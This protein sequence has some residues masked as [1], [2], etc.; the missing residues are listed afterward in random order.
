MIDNMEK[1]SSSE[2]FRTLLRKLVNVEKIAKKGK[3]EKKYCSLQDLNPG[4]VGKI[5]N[6]V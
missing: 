6:S 5:R 2:L 4:P 3:I 1:V